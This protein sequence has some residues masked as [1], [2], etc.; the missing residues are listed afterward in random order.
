MLD[1]STI[2]ADVLLARGEY[3]T[4][5]AAHEDA[6]KSLQMLCGE[7]SSTASKVLRRM[8]PDNEAVP[9]SADELL[10]D[11]R[12]SLDAIELCVKQI[13]G[14]AQQKANIK[15]QAWGRK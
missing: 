1:L 10:A 3:A 2:P 7:L 15:Q 13:E 14:L 4:V 11:G 6:K 5:R 8:Q 12:A 9:D